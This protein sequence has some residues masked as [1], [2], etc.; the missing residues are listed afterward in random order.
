MGEKNVTGSSVLLY[1]SLALQV[2]NAIENH[3]LK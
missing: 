3:H 2:L 1:A